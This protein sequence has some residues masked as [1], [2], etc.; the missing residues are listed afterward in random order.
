MKRRA[1]VKTLGAALGLAFAL[2]P[3]NTWA[4]NAPE[5]SPKL[6]VLLVLGD[7][8]SAE[9]G[10][11]RGQGW[12]KQLEVR[13]AQE[14]FRYEVINASISGETSSGGL[15]RLP[16]L[17]R[18]H[19]PTVVVLELGANDGLRGLSVQALRANL[20]TMVKACRNAGARV[21]LVGMRMPPNYGRAYAED[22]FAAFGAV[23]H[24]EKV[25]HVPFLF[26]GFADKS[27]LFQADHLHPTEAAQ[28]LML[29]NVWPKLRPL[30][31]ARAS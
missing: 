6:P 28:P 12:V 4:T 25:A 23:A 13:L 16:D 18:T 14:R 3:K 20:Q 31:L 9:Y 8:L 15:A 19:R 7:S 11:P 30:L 2:N 1:L 27:E 10:L 22:F 17:L 29:D 26:D 5:R 24:T 21:L